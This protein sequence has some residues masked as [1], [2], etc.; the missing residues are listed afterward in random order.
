MQI[1]LWYNSNLW[2]ISMEKKTNNPFAEK[3]GQE[4]INFPLGSKIFSTE[5]I[6]YLWI[7]GRHIAKKMINYTR[8][9]KLVGKNCLISINMLN[10][11]VKDV[12]QGW[13][14]MLVILLGDMVYYFH[15]PEALLTK[16]FFYVSCEDL[17]LM[18]CIVMCPSYMCKHL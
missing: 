16:E 8:T 13:W 2:L 1:Y 4:K 3:N 17:G 11:R 14:H 18:S 9:W 6:Q 5:I 12:T 10:C 15:L 7:S